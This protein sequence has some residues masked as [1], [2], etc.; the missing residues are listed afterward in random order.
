MEGKV[1]LVANDDNAEDV[2]VIKGTAADDSLGDGVSTA[3]EI[4]FSPPKKKS[5]NLPPRLRVKEA[6]S[7]VTS[8]P[9]RTATVM[10]KSP[11]PS[12]AL[13]TM[14]RT[15]KALRSVNK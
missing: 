5:A 1:E 6:Q 11:H 10:K 3:F 13:R 7:L 8:R 4:E 12:L 14:S 2:I 9:V 15:K